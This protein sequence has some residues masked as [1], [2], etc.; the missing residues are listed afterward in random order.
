MKLTSACEI[1]ENADLNVRYIPQLNLWY[2]DAK[3]VYLN[4]HG[5]VVDAMQSQHKTI[6]HDTKQFSLDNVK[7][8]GAVV[9][10]I[11]G[12]TIAVVT[13]YNL[14]S[15][16]ISDLENKID[17]ISKVNTDNGENVKLLQHEV[18]RINAQEAVNADIINTMQYK[19]VSKK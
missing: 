12:I 2:D 13:Q 18:T 17:D 4:E 19:L 5:A 3:C 6:Q 10:Q 15:T 11:I 7:V 16:K 14:L 8:S 9:L 1:T